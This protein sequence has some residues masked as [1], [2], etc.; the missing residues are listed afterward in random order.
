VLARGAPHVELD[1]G[2]VLDA[3]AEPSFEP[4]LGGD[5]I[6]GD[7]VVLSSDEACSRRGS[8]QGQVVLLQDGTGCADLVQQLDAVARRGALAAL[9]RSLLGGLPPW[10]IVSDVNRV[11]IPSLALTE[12]DFDALVDRLTSQSMIATLA[13]NES[14]LGTDADGHVLLS[15]TEPV[16]PGSSGSHWDASVRR[17]QRSP[18]D[19]VSLLMEPA[20]AGTLRNEVKDLT[21]QLLQDIG[22]DDLVCGNGIVEGDEQCDEGIDNSDEAPDACRMN[23]LLPSCGDGVVDS[24]E[25][26]DAPEAGVCSDTCQSLDEQNQPE[27]RP[28]PDAGAAPPPSPIPVDAGPSK[29]A[30]KTPAKAV[31]SDG[32]SER[33]TPP[34][35]DIPKEGCA[36]HVHRSRAPGGSL[37]LLFIGLLLVR[38]R[39]RAGRSP[40][41]RS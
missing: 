9:T 24:G 2:S 7:L 23:C 1:D 27:P 19:P 31:D 33:A 4:F 25:G 37:V 39:G 26:C 10:G 29:P 32:G 8:L 40:C 35:V 12:E 5:A 3:V 11:S 38:V 28:A 22:W 17:V 36:C 18:S 16:Q 34:R 41:G 13:T 15:A 20:A 6:S 14:L 21:V 30:P